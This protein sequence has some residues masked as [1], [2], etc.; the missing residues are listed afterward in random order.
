VH[1]QAHAGVTVSLAAEWYLSRR[2]AYAWMLL[3]LYSICGHRK[4]VTQKLQGLRTSEENA[5]CIRV[6]CI[7]SSKDSVAH[8]VFTLGISSTTVAHAA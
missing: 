6:P 3:S 5:Y 4:C 1:A 2:K 8:A 7:L